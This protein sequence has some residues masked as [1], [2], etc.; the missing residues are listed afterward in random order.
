MFAYIV[1]FPGL[2]EPQARF[3]DLPQSEFMMTISGDA[4]IL[5]RVV[6][7]AEDRE[8]I[9]VLM[10]TPDARDLLQKLVGLAWMQG[11]RYGDV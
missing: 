11:T 1:R 6:I 3:T 9:K 4:N 7:P 8:Y 5:G 2:P 10:Q